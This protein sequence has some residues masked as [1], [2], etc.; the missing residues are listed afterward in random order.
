V[1]AMDDVF[2]PLADEAR[3]AL[4]ERPGPPAAVTG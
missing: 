2:P 4:A 1:L 3:E